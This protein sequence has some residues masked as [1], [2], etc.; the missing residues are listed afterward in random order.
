MA[1]AKENKGAGNPAVVSIEDLGLSAEITKK[2]GDFPFDLVKQI[3]VFE[4][5]KDRAR[6]C[7]A[8]MKHKSSGQRRYMIQSQFK[9][10]DGIW[11]TR[12]LK[13]VLS[14]IDVSIIAKYSKEALESLTS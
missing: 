12:A 5:T 2:Q 1:K 7:Y 4:S 11:K 14:P 3:A 8:V 13:K 6:T 10:K 9:A